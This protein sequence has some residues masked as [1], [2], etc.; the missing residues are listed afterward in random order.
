LKDLTSQ[1]PDELLIYILS[2]LN[3]KEAL[4]TSLLSHRWKHLWPF[5]T[6][7]LDFRHPDT[8]S[9]WETM[10]EN[11]TKFKSARYYFVVRVNRILKLHRASTIDEF[12]VCF[13]L[14]QI[15]R[16]DFDRWIDFAMSKGVK[17]FELDFTPMWACRSEWRYTFPHECIKTSVGAYCIKS[18]TSFTLMYV[19]VTDELLEHFLSN[20]PLLERLHVTESK[21]IVSLKVCGS[22]LKLKYLHIIEC[23]NFKSIEIFAPNLESFGHAGKRIDLHINYAPRLLHVH[24]GGQRGIPVTYAFCPLSNYLS[25]LESLSLDIHIF[26][27]VSTLNSFA[28]S[29]IYVYICSLI[30]SLF[31]SGYLGIP[32]ISNLNQS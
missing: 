14:D 23:N 31:F 15:F 17:R 12:R 6:G 5:F 20:C 25:Q 16:R 19:H 26:G 4:R 9:M 13:P 22:S 18:L 10:W 11:E 28:I 30:S 24:I 8:M 21:D 32:K 29:C 2:F 3:V 1:L 7:S 27:N